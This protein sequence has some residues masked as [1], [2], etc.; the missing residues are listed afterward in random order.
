MVSKW[1]YKPNIPHLKLGCT[2]QPSP[3]L[4]CWNLVVV[5][6][7]YPLPPSWVREPRIE[8]Q[9]CLCVVGED[10]FRSSSWFW[11]LR[12]D[13]TYEN[14]VC[15]YQQKLRWIR[16]THLKVIKEFKNSDWTVTEVAL[17][18][19]SPLIKRDCDLGHELQPIG[20]SEVIQGRRRKKHESLC[21][22]IY[23]CIYICCLVI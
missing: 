5:L 16:W 17:L 1:V 2:P 7:W 10:F 22:Y 9:W 14:D 15:L 23:I 11:G 20:S 12:K 18:K 6:P 13:W 21:I 8:I 19:C 3:F 4:R